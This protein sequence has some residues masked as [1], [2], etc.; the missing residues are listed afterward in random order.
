[1]TEIM[2]SVESVCSYP[3]TAKE[4]AAAKS[5]NESDGDDPVR[6]NELQDQL[7]WLDELA[8]DRIESRKEL[9]KIQ[10]LM[11][12]DKIFC[13]PEQPGQL[14]IVDKE[15]RS[16]NEKDEQEKMHG[17]PELEENKDSYSEIKKL[18]FGDG[19]SVNMSQHEKTEIE[20][21]IDLW[22]T[23]AFDVD[24]TREMPDRMESQDRNIFDYHDGVAQSEQADQPQL[25]DHS[26]DQIMTQQVQQQLQALIHL[27]LADSLDRPTIERDLVQSKD[28][29]ENEREDPGREHSR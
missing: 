5:T 26:V 29:T 7:D 19:P 24:L 17:A 16:K 9:P 25:E 18:I 22:H 3:R 4:L 11:H 15:E 1:M 12:N 23:S 8:D 21:R 6:R 28:D 2:L 13:V 14:T 10:R 27:R 20:N